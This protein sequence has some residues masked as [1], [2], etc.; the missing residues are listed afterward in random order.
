VI[1]W[2]GEVTRNTTQK[3]AIAAAVVLCAM[4]AAVGVSKCNV[5]DLKQQARETGAIECK[6][7]R[8]AAE[9]DALIAANHD[10]CA[11]VAVVHRKKHQQG[12]TR[13][14]QAKYM[15]CLPI[16]LDEYRRLRRE[17]LEAQNKSD[18]FMPR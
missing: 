5:D 15:E 17:A 3:G 12:E 18:S 8:S 14:D 11:A 7:T 6:K 4:M 10:D 16:G 13:L 2:L 1:A 9:C